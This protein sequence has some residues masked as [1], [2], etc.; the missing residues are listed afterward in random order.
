MAKDKKRVSFQT[1]EK[2]IKDLL[3]SDEDYDFREEEAI[4]P[5]P[6]EELPKAIQDLLAERENSGKGDK[7]KTPRRPLPKLDANSLLQQSTGLSLLRTLFRNNPPPPVIDRENITALNRRSTIMNEANRILT[8]YKHWAHAH[9]PKLTFEAFLERL[10][11]GVSKDST[12][13]EYLRVMNEKAS[14]VSREELAEFTEARF[15]AEHLMAQVG[16]EGKLEEE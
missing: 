3:P 16:D 1:P 2:I 13:R 8:I 5:P 7:E 10:E 6:P 4:L 15:I 9:F 12:L 11:N 14:K